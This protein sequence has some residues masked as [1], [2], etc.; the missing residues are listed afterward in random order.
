[1]KILIFNESNN[2]YSNYEK[3]L[4]KVFKKIKNKKHLQIIL[5]NDDNIQKL[6]LKYRDKNFPT[7]VLSFISNEEDSLGDIFISIDHMKKQA[8]KY[9]HSE[10]REISF[11]AVH[12]YLHLI[13][14]DHKTKDDEKEM[15]DLTEEILKKV[16]LGRIK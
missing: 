16:K 6:N 1:M 11:L 4:K 13:G 2:D 10:N 12:G 15:M 3:I 9:N 5:T 7:D 8:F 14:Y